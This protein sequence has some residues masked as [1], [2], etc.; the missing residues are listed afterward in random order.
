VW[1]SPVGWAFAFD[2][3]FVHAARNRADDPRVVLMLELDRPL[4]AGERRRNRVVQK[5]FAL[6]PQV[7]G[8]HRRLTEVDSAVNAGA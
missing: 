5:A 2:D 3:T 8:G 1:S 7:R 4:P 6:H